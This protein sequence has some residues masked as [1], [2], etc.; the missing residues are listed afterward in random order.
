MAMKIRTISV[1]VSAP[2]ETVYNFLADIENFPKWA[3]GYCECLELRRNGWLAYT[4]QGEMIV[5]LE[6]DDG[7]GV[8]DIRLGASADK[9]NVFPLR[10]W[11]RSRD[12]TV[13]SFTF[14]DLPELSEE[15]HERHF[16]SW[17]IDLQGFS[18][19]FGGGEIHLPGWEGRLEGVGL[20]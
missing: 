7:T 9:L 19:R 12:E 20:N 13:V 4:T 14:S 5:E 8:I 1:A 15:D 18:W 17:L 10:V 3:R 11:Q 2:S 6:S 16:Q